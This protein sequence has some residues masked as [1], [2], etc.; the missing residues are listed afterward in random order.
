MRF[1]IVLLFV[2][3][4]GRVGYDEIVSQRAILCG[5]G[6]IEADEICD[7]N[8]D[9]DNDG[10]TECSVDAG[11]VCS[12]EPSL[13]T[14]CGTPRDEDT[15]A[16]YTFDQLQG[17]GLGNDLF[18]DNHGVVT[19]GSLATI[20]G[21]LGCGSALETVEDAPPFV[22]IAD[23]PDWHLTSGS[24]DF[25][26]YYRQDLPP[27][28]PSRGFVSRDAQASLEAGH[29][30][31]YR[32]CGN[33]FGVRLQGQQGSGQNGSRCTETA[34]P[35][36]TWVHVGINFGDGQLMELY[37]DGQPH[38]GPDVVGCPMPNGL[39]CEVD[40]MI[41]IDGNSNPLLLGAQC[42][43]CTDGL[44]DNVGGGLDGA[45]DHLRISS[46]RRNF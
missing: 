32:M 33:Y 15:L 3:A 38:N 35:G 22:E 19:G 13:C 34:I 28:T 12:G 27:S 40:S 8:N 45:I 5:N 9:R 1:A 43:G 18:G 37:I 25:W 4:C 23:S 20:D 29:L 17:Q 42:T 36:D 39:V 24:L 10:C 31:L 26:V 41:G 30:T 46:K 16:L 44:A 7:D 11:W 21:P 14:I 6:L 2:G